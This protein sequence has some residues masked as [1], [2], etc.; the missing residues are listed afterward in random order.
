MEKTIPNNVYIYDEKA[1]RTM[2]GDERTEQTIAFNLPAAGVADCEVV[3]QRKKGKVVSMR[4]K[5]HGALP[6][7]FVELSAKRGTPSVCNIAEFR[8]SSRRAQMSDSAVRAFIRTL[9]E[10]AQHLPLDGFKAQ[11]V[12][13]GINGRLK[14]EFPEVRDLDRAA[15][16]VFR[17]VLESLAGRAQIIREGASQFTNDSAYA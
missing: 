1:T 15:M 14:V 2:F 3:I 9:V 10:Y 16:K 17:P 8:N 6:G 7:I 13:D 12:D 11:G 5:T 4:F